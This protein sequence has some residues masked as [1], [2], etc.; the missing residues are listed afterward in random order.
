V[1]Y[2][3]DKI[4]G[5]KRKNKK[6]NYRVCRSKQRKE[7]YPLELLIYFPF[8]VFSSRKI[9]KVFRLRFTRRDKD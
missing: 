6:L 9:N 3:V 7:N 5:S 1:D 2:D 8:L 4:V